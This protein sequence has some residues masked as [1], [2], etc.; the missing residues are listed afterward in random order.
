LTDRYAPCN[1]AEVVLAIRDD[2][3]K[4]ACEVTVAVRVTRR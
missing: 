2:S 4:P 3:G 1:E